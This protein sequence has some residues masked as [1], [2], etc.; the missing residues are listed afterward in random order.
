MNLDHYD[1][2]LPGDLIA[3]H[4]L[5]NRD[6]ARLLIVDRTEGTISHRRIS[7]LPEFLSAEDAVVINNTQVVAAR[8]VGYRVQTG[9]KWEG[10]F[11]SVDDKDNWNVLSKTRGKL[12]KGEV[13]QLLLSLI[14]I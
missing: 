6:S 12:G 10:L 5:P 13:I 4:P 8:L 7:D 11:L 14:H 3:Q 1:Y 2:H 9:G